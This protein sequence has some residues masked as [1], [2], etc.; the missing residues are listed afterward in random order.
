MLNINKDTHMIEGIEFYESPNYDHRPSNVDIDTIIIH[1]IS[2]PRGEYNNN[3]IIDLFQNN[4]D[5][6]KHESFSNLCDLKVS[7]HILITREGKVTQFVPFNYRAW[8]AGDSRYNNRKNFNDF[9]IGIELEGTTDTEFTS[10]QYTSLNEVI[11]V[12]KSFY[13]N[14]VSDNILGHSDI[15]PGRKTDPGDLFDWSKVK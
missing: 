5:I 11:V 9:S 2:L 12:L 3:N 8:H 1:C 13:A 4:L 14:I 15:A 7:S 10:E 6:S